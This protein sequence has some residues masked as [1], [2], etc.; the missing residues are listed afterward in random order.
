MTPAHQGDLPEDRAGTQRRRR[1]PFREIA[2]LT[3]I[4][5]FRVLSCRHE[6]GRKQ[7]LECAR[8]SVPHDLCGRSRRASGLIFTFSGGEVLS[9]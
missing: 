7:A 5:R 9:F 2:I 8:S 4:V 1:L 3:T 6:N